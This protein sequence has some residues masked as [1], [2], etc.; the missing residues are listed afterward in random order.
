[1]FRVLIVDDEYLMREALAIMISKVPNFEIVA[2]VGNGEEAIEVCKRN[3]V[4]VVFMD[5]VMP[6]ISGIKASKKIQDIDPNIV[7]YIISGYSN[8]AL[9]KE[10]LKS[11]VKEYIPKPISLPVIKD[12]L[13]NFK[14]E[15]ND[16]SSIIIE[17]LDIVE[18]KDFGQVYY[19]IPKI[20]EYIYLTTEKDPRDIKDLL[21]LIRQKLL[22]YTEVYDK[23]PDKCE[24]LFPID[25]VIVH[26]VK[27]I[28]LWMLDIMNYVFQYLS[29]RKYEVLENVFVYV[30]ENI[31]NNIGL[32]DI[33]EHCAIS[34][35]Y[36]S[37][38]FKSQ[39]NIS[40]MEYIH[41]RKLAIAKVYLTTNASIAD[42]SFN[43]GY[44]E[45][46][47]FSKVFKKYENMTVF[48]YRKSLEKK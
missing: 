3:T 31:K 40:V 42:I 21:T 33:V 19:K 23:D 4:D 17:V 44:S 26:D 11:N 8:F 35:G 15:N 48:Q 7:I 43:L 9:A 18:G 41:M 28:E 13:S 46:G 14:A 45:R 1:M 12:I 24:N 16:V 10:A 47:Y 36:L 25:Y 32:N 37:R 39:F 34:Q 30:D 2:S 22:K 38:I 27:R 6:G 5:I 29:T 20:S